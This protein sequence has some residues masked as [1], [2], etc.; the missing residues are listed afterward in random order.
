MRTSTVI[1]G[2]LFPLAILTSSM[3]QDAVETPPKPINPNPLSSLTLENLSATRSLP[4]F[5]PSRTAPAVAA[6]PLESE[7]VAIEEPVVDQDQ[8]PPPLQLVG[9]VLTDTTQTALLLD[10]TSQ[11]IHRLS[12]GDEYEGWSLTIVDGRSVEFRSGDR[13]EGLTMFESF[14]S[15]PTTSALSNF[16]GIDVPADGTSGVIEPD[17]LMVPDEGVLPQEGEMQPAGDEPIP[18]A[19]PVDFD[20]ALGTVPM[21]EEG[22]LPANTNS[23]GNPG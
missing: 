3:A 19:P 8:P 5:T 17:M 16:P 4:L 22:P 23:N 13:V 15:P 2:F 12:S 7:P 9:I 1:L 10:S 20:P 18:E 14:P 21:P 6:T 11:E